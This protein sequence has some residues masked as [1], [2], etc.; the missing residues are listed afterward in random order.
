MDCGLNMFNSKSANVFNYIKFKP[1]NNRERS[2][3]QLLRGIAIIG[4]IFNHAGLNL[5]GG[6]IGVDILFVVSGFLIA[7]IIKKQYRSNGT[8][9]LSDFYVRRLLRLIPALVFVS[10]VVCVSMILLN[11][12]SGAQQN[13]AKTAL[14]TSLFIGNYIILQGQNNYFA[15][16]TFYNPLMHYW[17][18]SVEWQFYII[19]S[20][21]A[22]F[23][24]ST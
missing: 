21:G 10:A 4:V 23:M 20:L 8:I 6:F 3:I 22:F 12:P 24:S 2:D 5:A 16:N 9:I 13:S 11:N 19:F 15:N 7:E 18:L 17:T 1:S 14:T